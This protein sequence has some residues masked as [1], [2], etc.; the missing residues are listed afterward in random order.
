MSI[1]WIHKVDIYK[2][3]YFLCKFNGGKR[4]AA[5]LFRRVLCLSRSTESIYRIPETFVPAILL[6]C[7]KLLLGLF[8]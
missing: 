4:P 1:L 6:C 2:R 7:F 8:Q 3:I 5:L